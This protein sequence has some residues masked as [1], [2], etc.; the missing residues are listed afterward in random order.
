MKRY[1]YQALVTLYD[2][3]TGGPA[4]QLSPSPRRM[5]IRSRNHDS[6]DTQVFAALVACEEDDGPL[7]LRGRRRLAT[8]RLA[9]DDVAD[10]IGIGDH[11]DLW[12]GSDVGEGVVTRRLFT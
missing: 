7:R 5:V 11:F 10:H 2:S 1:K 9:G 8:L 4:V 6:G 3:G 12:L